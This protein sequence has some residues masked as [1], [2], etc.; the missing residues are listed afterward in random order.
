MASSC[1]APS[2]PQI[3][4]AVVIGGGPSGIGASLAL[5]GWLPYHRNGCAVH[6][7]N[8]TRLLQELPDGALGG[9]TIP[10]LAAGLRG[11]SNNPLALL[12]DALQHPGTDYGWRAPCCLELRHD[13]S[14]AL[15]HAVIDPGPPGGSWHEMHEA[16]RTLSPG[17]WMELPGFKLSEFLRERES[18]S[19]AAAASSAATRQPRRLVADYYAAAAARYGV[20]PHFLA[21]RVVAVHA[22]DNASDTDAGAAVPAWTVELSDGAVLRSHAL[23]LATGTAGLPRRL[24]IEGE[25][26]PYVSH[27]CIELPASTRTVLVLGA[28]LSAA[29]CIV[30]HLQQG[31]RVLHAFRGTADK[32]KLGSKFGSAGAT[33]MYPEYHA[34]VQAMR[35]PL[36]KAKL[37]GGEYAPYARRDLEAM[38][39]G[40]QCELARSD[41]LGGDG[42]GAGGGSG[43]ETSD[44]DV[45]DMHTLRVDAVAILVGSTPDLAFLPD[46]VRQALEAA[47][48]PSDTVGGI[49]ATHPVFFDVDPWR[50]E[51]RVWP[52]LH[53]LGPLRGDNF[54]RFAIHDGHGVAMSLRERRR[55]PPAPPPLLS[56]SNE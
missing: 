42:Y 52:T 38:R 32:T 22:A 33:R 30:H 10:R 29:D 55:P 11:R 17:P 53:A 12:F 40:G 19:P 26:L 23:V 5:A 2:Q 37:L 13:P 28:G 20:A 31:R 4:D 36:A 1:S 49:R 7:A 41:S 34:L 46:S 44:G 39:S 50:F 56:S 35:A 45:A 6:D 21:R 8:L 54:V 3:L 47:G 27:R 25:D 48:P 24:G 15:D 18:L 51:S 43:G 9:E 16:T 14:A